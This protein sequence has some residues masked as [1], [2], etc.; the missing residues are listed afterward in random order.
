[1][2]LKDPRQVKLARG[3][4]GD[5]IGFDSRGR[6]AGRTLMLGQ[7]KE[8]GRV[9]TFLSAEKAKQALRE[10]VQH[11]AV[12]S[13]P[14]SAPAQVIH[15]SSPTKVAGTQVQVINRTTEGGELIR[16]PHSV[17]RERPKSEPD[18]GLFY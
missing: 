2:H 14:T 1:V 9:R 7:F 17:R 8:N 12:T 13:A 4:T 5:G 18:A 11:S 3:A 15:R 6:F 16:A 10:A